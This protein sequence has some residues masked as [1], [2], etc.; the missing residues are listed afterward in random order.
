M[1]ARVIAL[2]VAAVLTLAGAAAA[3]APGTTGPIVVPPAPTPSAQP[4]PPARPTSRSTTA[5]ITMENWAVA[6]GIGGVWG[7]GTVDYNGKSYDIKIGG[8]DLL[9]VG[10]AKAYGSGY[11]HNLNSIE[12]IEG[13]YSAVNPAFAFIGGAG[14]WSMENERG[15]KLGLHN[16]QIGAR[17]GVGPGALTIQLR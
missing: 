1:I 4:A 5:T 7:N 17:A 8:F 9:D 2:S 10:V 11:V 13:S 6:F 16:Y 15:V 12:E 3:D 14:G